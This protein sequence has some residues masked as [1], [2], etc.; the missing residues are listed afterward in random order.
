VFV[1]TERKLTETFSSMK[2]LVTGATGFIGGNVAKSAVQ[3]GYSVI[4]IGRSERPC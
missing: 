2:L 1:S 3:E 4:G